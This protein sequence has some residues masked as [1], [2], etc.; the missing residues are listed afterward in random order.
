MEFKYVKD[1]NANAKCSQNCINMNS[2][3]CSGISIN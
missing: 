1:N 2:G 3:L